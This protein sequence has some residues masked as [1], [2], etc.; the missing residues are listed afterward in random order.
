M[1][2]HYSRPLMR[3]DGKTVICVI[4]ALDE[5]GKIGRVVGGFPAGIVTEIVVVDDGS[6]DGTGDEARAGGA[7]VLRHPRRQ[8]SG[9]AIRTGLEYAL[10]AGCEFVAVMAGDFQ[11]DPAEL[12]TLLAPV[13]AGDADLVQG[14]RRLGGLRAPQMP[15]HR[16]VLTRFYT[17]CFRGATHSQITDATNGYRV[18]RVSLLRDPRLK[19]DQ[20]WLNAYELEPYVL[21]QALRLGY[22]VEERPVLKRYDH[23]GGFTKMAGAGDWWSIFRPV[24]LL[25]LRLR[26]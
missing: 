19:L 4:P 24:V 7:T 17:A 11:D 3:A 23:E 8:G 9:A 12:A 21:F 18:I 6:S 26:S 2:R 10:G 5:A 1:V 15:V 20:P 16:R 14:S 22:R 13:L 25:A